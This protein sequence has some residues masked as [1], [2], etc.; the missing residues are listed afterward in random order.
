MTAFERAY[1]CLE[2]FLPPLHSMVRRKLVRL[3]RTSPN[4]SILDVGG[5][6][7]PYTIGVPAS[8][9]I[10][11]LPRSTDT[12]AQL[13]LGLTAEMIATT[14]SRRSN[15]TRVVMDDMTQSALPDATFDCVVAVEVLEHVE[16]DFAFVQQVYRVLKPGGVFLLTTPN[17]DWIKVNNPDHKRHYR[18]VQL[19]GLLAQ[20]FGDVQVEY[21]VRGG[22]LHARGLRAWSLSA[23]LQTAVGMV[24]NVANRV[25]SSDPT[26]RQQPVGTHHLIAE[27]RKPVAA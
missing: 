17:G 26:L 13:N 4:P 9:T 27:A 14:Q 15:I 25:Q 3:A 19:A 1:V 21:A 18:R 7:S 5:R 23:P 8:V 20:C 22:P 12:Q 6:K 10:S 11:D 16:A 2:P 24:C